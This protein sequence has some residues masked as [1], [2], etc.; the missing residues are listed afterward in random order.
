MGCSMATTLVKVYYLQ[1]LLHS[2]KKCSSLPHFGKDFFSLY[3]DD[4]QLSLVGG[5]DYVLWHSFDLANAL[6][7]LVEQQ[8]RA[9][10]SPDKS[11]VTASPLSLRQVSSRCLVTWRRKSFAHNRNFSHRHH[12]WETSGSPPIPHTRALRIKKAQ[13]KVKR[14]VRFKRQAWL[15]HSQ[16]G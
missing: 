1:A 2:D 8:V 6:A 12:G 16:D 15:C 13:L 4:F 3:I 7:A 11:Q 9:R 5:D 14:A 10:L